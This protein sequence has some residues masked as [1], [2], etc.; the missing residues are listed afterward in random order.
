[1]KDYYRFLAFFAGVNRYG[2]HVQLPIAPEEE[3][4]KYRAEIEVHRAKLKTLQDKIDVIDRRVLPDLSDVEKEEFKHE[5]SRFAIV[6]KRVPALIT[7]ADFDQYTTELREKVRLL[8]NPP[9]ALAAALAVTEEPAPRPT[10]ILLRGNAHVEGDL[11][12]PG[13]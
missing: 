9:K 2:D 11:V 7:Q 5:Q 1:Q 13:F 3:Q 4:K 10:H 12:E 6:K 8:T